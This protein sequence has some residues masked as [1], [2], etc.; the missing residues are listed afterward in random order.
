MAPVSYIIT[1]PAPVDKAG[2]FRAPGMGVN[3][4]VTMGLNKEQRYMIFE[5]RIVV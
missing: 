1:R 2:L 5:M 4:S 3:L